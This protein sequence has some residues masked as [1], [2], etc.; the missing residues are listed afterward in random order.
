MTAETTANKIDRILKNSLFPTGPPTHNAEKGGERYRITR[1]VII[2]GN[3]ARCETLADHTGGAQFTI[4]DGH[5]R[6][7][8]NIPPDASPGLISRTVTDTCDAYTLQLNRTN[9]QKEKE[10]N[11]LRTGHNFYIDVPTTAVATEEEDFETVHLTIERVPG[12]TDTPVYALKLGD[13]PL[14]LISAADARKLATTLAVNL[15]DSGVIPTF[16]TTEEN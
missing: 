11:M 15:K 6:A 5:N 2:N 14:H 1:R 9:Q 10:T 3:T 12:L 16:P 13:S 7:R 4:T 8:Y